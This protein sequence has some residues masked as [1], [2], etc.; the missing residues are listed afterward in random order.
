MKK[1]CA[2]CGNEISEPPRYG[3]QHAVGQPIEWFCSKACARKHGLH[4]D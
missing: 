1:Y 2:E 4:I 3:H